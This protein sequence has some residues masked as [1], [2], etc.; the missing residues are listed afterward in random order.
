MIHDWLL[1]GFD[2]QLKNRK[3][4]NWKHR[5][6]EKFEHLFVYICF[7]DFRLYIVGPNV[8]GENM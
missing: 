5:V 8:T 2:K 3:L 1:F 4:K 7:A 6:T